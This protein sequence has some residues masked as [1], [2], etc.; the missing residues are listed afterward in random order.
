M[1]LDDFLNKFDW[2]NRVQGFLWSLTSWWPRRRSHKG[3]KVGGLR[4]DGGVKRIE[5]DRQHSTGMQAERAL[6][7]AHIPIAGRGVTSKTAYFLVRSRQWKWAL[8]VLL[9]AGVVVS[10]PVPADVARWAGGQVGPVPIWG[11][12][13]RAGECRVTGVTKAAAGRGGV[14]SIGSRVAR[15][16][17]LLGGL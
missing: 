13:T 12:G 9:R 2:I 7:R 10:S 4:I 5:V 3:R 14:K 8:Y 15:I 11:T 16:K 17:G 1:T 6:Q